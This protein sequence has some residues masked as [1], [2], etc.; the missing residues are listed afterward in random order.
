LRL[1]QQL[2]QLF[3]ASFQA[4]D[5]QHTQTRHASREQAR[6][7]RGGALHKY[8]HSTGS[9]VMAY[10][11]T[12]TVFALRSFNPVIPQENILLPFTSDCSLFI[13]CVC[14]CVC[15]CVYVCQCAC[16]VHMDTRT[17]TINNASSHKM[18]YDIPTITMLSF[19]ACGW[20]AEW[21]L[22]MQI[23]H[24]INSTPVTVRHYDGTSF[25]NFSPFPLQNTNTHPLPNTHTY[26]HIYMAHMSTHAHTHT[27]THPV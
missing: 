5:L 16:S 1:H 7:V 9:L 25:C 8:H 6:A 18:P 21:P 24:S 20:K 10:L 15:V 19:N 11:A 13:V 2:C 23:L 17:H 3:F 14:V 12:H 27:H 4:L 26:T 22:H